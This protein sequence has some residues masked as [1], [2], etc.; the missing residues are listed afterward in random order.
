M[1]ITKERIKQI[2]KEELE[3]EASVETKTEMAE[4]FKELYTLFPR[5]NGLDNAEIV[6]LNQ[7]L[8]AALKVA[9]DGNARTELSMALDKLGV[10]L[11]E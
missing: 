1:K 8:T 10:D 4:K 11:N 6:L 9:K 3:A 2:I 5:I 7:L